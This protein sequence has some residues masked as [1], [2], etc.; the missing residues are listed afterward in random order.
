MS[1]SRTGSAPFEM[2]GVHILISGSKTDKQHVQQDPKSDHIS[3]DNENNAKSI[4]NWKRKCLSEISEVK[5]KQLIARREYEKKRKA[6][7]CPEARKK[8][9][10]RKREST[11]KRRPNENL[12]TREKRLARQREY[13]KKT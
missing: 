4:E 9:L 13:S 11:R 1:C 6:N 7:E 2:K 8:R 5:E 3:S 12:E 10:A